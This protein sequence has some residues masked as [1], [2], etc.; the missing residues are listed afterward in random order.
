MFDV[1]DVQAEAE[2]EIAEERK[3]VAK[4]RIKS[5]LREIAQAERIVANLRDEYAVLLQ[6]IGA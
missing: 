6:D 1:K 5:K 4:A 3:T 2:K